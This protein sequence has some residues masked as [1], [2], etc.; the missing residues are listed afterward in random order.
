MKSKKKIIMGLLAAVIL[1]GAV[2]TAPVVPFSVKAA[3]E[4][5][6]LSETQSLSETGKDI[7]VVIDPGHGGSNIGGQIPGLDEKNATLITALAMKEELEKY[8]GIAVYLT[9][10]DDSELSLAQR[11]QMAAAVGADFFFSL[12]YNKAVPNRLY[13]AEVWIPSLGEGYSKGYACGDLILNELCDGYGLYRRGIKTKLNNKGTDYYGVIKNA[14]ALGIPSMIIEHCHLDNEEDVPY[15]NSIEKLQ[16]L[17]RLDAT[18][19]AKYFR[20][21]SSVLGVDYSDVQSTQIAPPQIPVMQDVTPPEVASIIS[22]KIENGQIRAVLEGVDMQSGILY[23]DYSLDGGATWSALQRW[24]SAERRSTV[25]IPGGG[26]SLTIR[27]YNGYDLAAQ[28]N[29]V[30]F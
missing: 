21:K 30:T 11:P 9:R 18:G 24:S 15:F 1:A 26:G 28:S 22:A 29:T 19:V 10:Y 17:G 3:S 5:Q 14:T 7:V 12:H 2:I 16:Q 13:G 6:P 20:L 23:Y 25:T 8:E 27:L 4:T